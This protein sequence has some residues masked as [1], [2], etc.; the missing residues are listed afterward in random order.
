MLQ[1]SDPVQASSIWPRIQRCLFAFH[2]LGDPEEHLTHR[3]SP[4]LRSE[5]LPATESAASSLA[6]RT[7]FMPYRLP[8]TTNRKD[9]RLGSAT[10]RYKRQAKATSA[11][12]CTKVNNS[13]TCSRINKTP[14]Q[15]ESCAL[16][17]SKLF[18]S[19]SKSKQHS[20]TKHVC[21]SDA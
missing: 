7:H 19:P 20:K 13:R 21:S 10:T 14:Q 4:K 18:S 8:K 5:M 12:L 2:K 17:S 15:I 16:T 3:V 9:I 6:A 11:F 1:A